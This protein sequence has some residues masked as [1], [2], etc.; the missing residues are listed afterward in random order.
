[1]QTDGSPGGT[2]APDAASPAGAGICKVVRINL[3][4]QGGAASLAGL[5]LG[6]AEPVGF[7][8]LAR[9]VVC[10]LGTRAASTAPQPPEQQG[11]GDAARVSFAAVPSPMD[12]L[13]IL[14]LFVLKT[15]LAAGGRE[16]LPLGCVAPYGQPGPLPA[17]G[18]WEGFLLQHNAS[19]SQIPWA[20]PAPSS[21]APCGYC[22]GS[23]PPGELPAPSTN[24][25]GVSGILGCHTSP[26]AKPGP[27]V[28]GWGG[29]SWSQ[30]HSLL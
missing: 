2:L 28:L 19:C 3:A 22:S 25:W 23:N 14:G 5:A 1:M 27:G 4:A 17:L 18:L 24:P 13:L 30:P 9:G 11:T 10:A 15:F 21:P 12:H 7:A 20:Q 29:P 26:A 8:D 16:S 6:R